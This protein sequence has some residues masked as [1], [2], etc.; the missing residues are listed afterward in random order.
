MT[1][2]I[3][4]FIGLI[5]FQIFI[6]ILLAFKIIS[7]QKIAFKKVVISSISKESI[8]LLP[9]ENLK[10]F[11]EPRENI[12]I[13]DGADWNPNIVKY[14]INSDA[15]NERFEY[16]VNKPERTFRI[17]SLG[18]S[19]TFGL[20]VDTKNNWTEVLEDKLNNYIKRCKKIEKIEII[21]LG[22]HGYDI[23]YEVERYRIRGTKY[24]A[25]M[26]LWMLFD[27]LRIKEN[28][29]PI[30]N[31]CTSKLSYQKDVL[32]YIDCWIESQNLLIRKIGKPKITSF[33]TEKF[34]SIFKY[35][36]KNIIVLD[37]LNNH[38][39]ILSNINKI[40]ILNN[41]K[42]AKYLVYGEKNNKYYL[43]DGHPNKE[44][45]IVIAEDVYGYLT[46]NKLIPCD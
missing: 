31:T 23:P 7:K 18:D 8:T 9:R 19:F 24:D 35:F 41:F 3:Y 21:N 40:K 29:T 45:H 12:V 27:P 11:Y 4:I 14:T 42:I 17:I 26:I 37:F 46:K 2:T 22:V 30:I 33:L 25:D 36:D 32:K 39:Q 38:N 5:L 10:Y 34:Q 28:M 6:I 20:S 44:G 16:S 15:L 13:E 43:Y 1:K